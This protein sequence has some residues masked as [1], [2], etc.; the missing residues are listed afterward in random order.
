MILLQDIATD[1]ISNNEII[2]TTTVPA[3]VGFFIYLI[4][5]QVVEINKETGNN[6]QKIIVLLQDILLQ[7]REKK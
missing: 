1:L 4:T 7:L 6:L 3:L 5:R 2:T